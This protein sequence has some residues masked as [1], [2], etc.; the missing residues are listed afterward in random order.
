VIRVKNGVPPPQKA[1][2]RPGCYVEWSHG[3]HV[4][5]RS[6]ENPGLFEVPNRVSETIL[7][8]LSQDI[9]KTITIS[10]QKMSF[11]DS[12]PHHN[13]AYSHIKIQRKS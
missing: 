13:F 7:S 4:A 10:L 6:T 5:A 9:Y 8:L 11:T 12:N 3:N 2:I 1:A